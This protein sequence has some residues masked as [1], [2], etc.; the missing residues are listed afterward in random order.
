MR[1]SK[2]VMSYL[3]P[4]LLTDDKIIRDEGRFVS[5]RTVVLFLGKLDLNCR[6]MEI[7]PFGCKADD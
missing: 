2:P 5:D 6:Y 4:R 7:N 3:E 1:E